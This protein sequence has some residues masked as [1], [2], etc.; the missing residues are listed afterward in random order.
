M[1]S[2]Y[3]SMYVFHKLDANLS[4]FYNKISIPELLGVDV[5]IIS[6][7]NMHFMHCSTFSIG[8]A[9]QL[10]AFFTF[11]SILRV[12]LS[13]VAIKALFNLLFFK[14][15]FRTIILFCNGV[16]ELFTVNYFCKFLE[17]FI[18]CFLFCAFTAKVFTTKVAIVKINVNIVT[19]ITFFV[20]L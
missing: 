9:G 3:F 11:K 20:F 7:S 8:P 13:T 10:P 4:G 14:C 6:S 18:M 19:L 15:T 2:N 12:G 17:L 1:S 16:M 5:I